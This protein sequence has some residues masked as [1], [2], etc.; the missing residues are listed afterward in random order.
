MKKGKFIIL[1]VFFSFFVFAAQASEGYKIKIK[2]TG[3]KDTLC[4]LA[5]HYGEK[6]YITDSA[7][8]DQNGSFVFEGKENLPGGIYLVVVPGR[9][10][11]EMVV[12][13]EQKFSVET[14][15]DSLTQHARFSG[16]SDNVLFNDYQ[17][18]MILKQQESLALR[19]KY[20]AV[21]SDVDSAK[22]YKEKLGFIDDQVMA[23]REK[24]LKESPKSFVAAIIRTM[25]EPDI[26][27][28][29]VDANGKADSGYVFRYFR[30]HFLDHVDF[31]DQRLLRTPLLQQKIHQY[32]NNLTLQVPDS[33]IAACDT[34]IEKS[35]ANKEV[36]RYAV[37]T[38]TNN[39]ETSKIMGFDA[40]FVH[41]AQ[42]YYMSN[43][44]YWA[45]STIKAKIADRVYKI[46]GNIIGKQ[47]YNL[48]MWDTS[49]HM[50]NLK[51]VK[52]K[53]TVVYFWD[54][55]CGHCKTETPKL[56]S[57][58]DSVKVHQVEVY[59]VGIESDP[60]IWKAYIREHNLHWINVSDLYN[61]TGFRNH[62]D[63][64]S[65][66]VVYL[67]DE[68]KNIIAKRIG[69]ETLREVLTDLI[70]KDKKPE[71]K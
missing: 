10:Y 59:A 5:N 27:E 42:K 25:G 68:K 49:G 26:P 56:V 19:D 40:I 3:L 38:L 63:I 37:V 62:Y 18:F 30:E 60:E 50:H 61:V 64:Y 28:I 2:V 53:Y 7:R 51:D 22:Y 17:K 35:R 1:Q 70:K 44:A 14:D 9:S 13:K 66:P 29:P 12:D 58:Y 71:L 32:I 67:L 6:Q 11:F 41:L 57:L 34:I 15:L 16:S 23:Y 24:I 8:V 69:V 52:A 65:T 33:I 39:Y 4:Y 45:D 47:A 46:T 54:P 48:A 36:F 21:K 55:T 20:N 43:D 31:S